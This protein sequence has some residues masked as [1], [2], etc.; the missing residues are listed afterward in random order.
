MSRPQ[1]A[2]QRCCD[3]QRVSSVFP[4]VAGVAGQGGEEP[5]DPED[6]GQAAAVGDREGGGASVAEV[7][8]SDALFG[9][10]DGGAGWAEDVVVGGGAGVAAGP[11]A[12][13]HPES[14]EG[15]EPLFGGV[16]MA[17]GEL[18]EL[19]AGEHP[20]LSQQPTQGGDRAQSAGQPS[21]PPCGRADRIEPLVCHG[22]RPS[23]HHRQ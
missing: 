12:V 10:Q 15:P 17:E 19:M 23:S 5:V 20:M 22:R 14:G 21:Q 16:E 18:G 4:V 9:G 6:L 13:Q 7:G 8:H 2:W 11:E 1:V 3:H